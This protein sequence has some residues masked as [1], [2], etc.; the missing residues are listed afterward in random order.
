MVLMNSA[1]KILPI[2]KG[3]YSSISTYSMLDMVRYQNCLWIAKKSQ[4]KDIA[5]SKDNA[6]SWMLLI[7]DTDTD[8]L[9]SIVAELQTKIASLEKALNEGTG[10]A[11]IVIGDDEPTE[12]NV[13]WYDT[14]GKGS[15]TESVE[16]VLLDLG[17]LTEDAIM[18]IQ[19][20]DSANSIVNA[21]PP[22]RLKDDVY[23]FN[24][25]Y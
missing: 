21:D 13:L 5:P 6:D 10:K 23:S 2:P 7:E 25:N 14:L 3:E 9:A 19:T 16:T 12:C 24:I 17:E 20:D 18:T 4:L 11:Q 8:V 22:Q 15:T 1:G